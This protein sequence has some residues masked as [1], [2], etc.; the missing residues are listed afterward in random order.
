[1]NPARAAA[2]DRIKRNIEESG[3]HIYLV[4]GGPGPRFAYTIGLRDALGAELVLA[5]AFYYEHAKDVSKIMHTLREQLVKLR[6]RGG[7]A[8]V[9]AAIGIRRLGSFTLRKA[10]TS[11]CRSLLLGAMDYYQVEDV[12]AYR[13]VP[14]KRHTT[15]DVPDMSVKWSAEAEPMWRWLHEPWPYS[16]PDTSTAMTDLDVLHGQPVTEACRWEEDYWELFARPGPKVRKKDARLVPLGC[17]IAAD[18]TLAPVI[19]LAIG[20]GVRRDNS[21]GAW[22]AWARHSTSS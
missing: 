21:R 10:H 11:W 16:A 2:L 19:D 15:I 9:P 5:G 13:V 18:P 17:L 7:P 22:N 6:P 14:E 12:D 1:M 4:S 20:E 8:D 3:F